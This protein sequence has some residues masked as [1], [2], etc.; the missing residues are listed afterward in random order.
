MVDAK[1]SE[2]SR[3]QNSEFKAFSRR[4]VPFL[5]SRRSFNFQGWGGPGW[6]FRGSKTSR[7]IMLIHH[8]IDP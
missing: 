5:Q 4:G 2:V 7:A 8:I 6:F 1:F 3:G